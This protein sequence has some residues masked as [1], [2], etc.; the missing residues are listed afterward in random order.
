MFM[1][2]PPARPVP[3]PRHIRDHRRQALATPPDAR[4]VAESRLAYEA[5]LATVVT[6]YDVAERVPAAKRD[7]CSLIKS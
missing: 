5:E 4:T 7:D 6:N 2:P 1:A 3:A